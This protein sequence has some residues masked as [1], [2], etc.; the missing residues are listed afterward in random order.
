VIAD[1]QAKVGQMVRVQ[2]NGALVHDLSGT[3]LP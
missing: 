1:G 2:I 3:I